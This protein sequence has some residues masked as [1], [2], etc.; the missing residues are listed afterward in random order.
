MFILWSRV[1][2]TKRPLLL[3][4]GYMPLSNWAGVIS[5]WGWKLPGTNIL[6]LDA[7]SMALGH[8]RPSR[9][10]PLPDGCWLGSLGGQGTSGCN[11][12]FLAC[13]AL[14]IGTCYFAIHLPFTCMQNTIFFY[15][16]FSVQ[17]VHTLH[18]MQLGIC[19]T[20]LQKIPGLCC[21]VK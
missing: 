14:T 8:H 16:A 3:C 11:R 12:D 19:T 5:K 2:C 9:W 15:N 18:N 4:R 7:K 17:K 21:Y 13:I 20:E 1:V 6:L 10:L